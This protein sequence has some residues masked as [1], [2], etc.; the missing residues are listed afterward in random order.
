MNSTMNLRSFLL[1]AAC[2]AA[3]SALAH[4]YD[5]GDLHI[6]HPHARPTIANMP[7]SAAYFNVENKG[8]SADKLI[9]ASSPVAKS[10]EIHTMSMDNGVMKMREVGTIELKPGEK[11][12]MQPGG[13]YHLMLMGLTQQLKPGDRFP[14]TLTFEKAGKKEVNV[15][16][17]RKPGESEHQHQH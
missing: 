1:A 5:V 3:G 9:G 2:F 4:S 7:A 8:K 14:M 12:M 13:G 15:A 10:V 6:Q 11:I 17:D 16:V